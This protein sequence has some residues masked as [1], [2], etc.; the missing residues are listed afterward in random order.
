MSIVENLKDLN[1]P[2]KTKTCT[3]DQSKI[4]PVDNNG[5][6]IYILSA[7]AGTGSIKFGGGTIDPIF[8]REF[9]AG[10]ARSSGKVSAPFTFTST[11]NSIQV[12]I[13]GSTFR[14]IV[15]ATG[16]GLTGDIVAQDLQEKITA[17]AGIGQLEAS[18][19]SFL[20]ATCEFTNNK[21]V[22]VAGSVSNTYVGT[23]KTSVKVAAG[24]SNDASV[25]LGFDKYVN[26]EDLSSKLATETTLSSSYTAGGVTFSVAT[27]SG[28]A[29]GQA[30]S[31]YDG[32]NREYFVASGVT[33]STIG[34][35]GTNGLTNSYASGAIIQ[36]IFERD[37]DAGIESPYKTVDQITRFTLRSIG[38]QIDFSQ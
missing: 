21:F 14:S 26:T 4:I 16:T 29:A 12:S 18:N 9:K 8:V 2:L 32:T 24:V 5:D 27:T 17:Y 7:T 15:L 35:S 33:S 37:P 13:D 31:V 30:F 34:I 19:L 6:E 28:L 38:N 23:G 10:Y 20:N 1:L 3:L 25:S 36:K 11:N 22:I